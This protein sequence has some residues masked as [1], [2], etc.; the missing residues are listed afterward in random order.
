MIE[1][2]VVA[3]IVDTTNPAVAARLLGDLARLVA[4]DPGLE[5]KALLLENPSTE[6]A[7]S[8]LQLDDI[9]RGLAIERIAR[10][11]VEG[12][13]ARGRYG[14]LEPAPGRWPIATARTVLQR[15]AAERA[16]RSADAV[17]ILDE[18]LR[19]SPLLDA[20]KNGEP[21]LSARVRRLRD[22]RIDVAVG[23]TLGSPP[24]PARG[25]ARVNLEDVRRHLDEVDRLPPDAAWPDHAAENARTRSL[26]PEYYYDLSR[27]H[28][29][30]GARPMWFERRS[31]DETV[32]SAFARLCE[33]VGGLV[34]GIPVTRALPESAPLEEA[35]SPLARGG[36]TLVLRPELLARIPN[37]APRIGGR[38]TRRSDMLW[39]R[40][41]GALLGARFSRGSIVTYHD[42]RGQGRSSFDADKLVDDL[43]GSALVA[44]L[45][46]LLESGQIQRR[47]RPSAAAI[48]RAGQLYV[49]R[50]EE[51]LHAIRRSE[52]RALD[53]LDA[54]LAR[55]APRP[56]QRGFLFHPAHALPVARLRAHAERLRSAYG[57]SVVTC[58]PRA[59]LADVTR[60]FSGLLDEVDA[61]EINAP[62]RYRP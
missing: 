53:L 38:V 6:R 48:E 25:A 40:L 20:V 55:T 42:R 59:E 4:V 12:D 19:L 60:F 56:T 24:V 43:H 27:A 10:V 22:E 13:L 49:A 21:P 1:R 47:Q 32:Q 51:R 31:L 5:L 28:A 54:I 50:A 57:S 30:A 37:L 3:I 9:A 16:L 26:L 7:C 52:A 11:S 34:D 35:R 23:P 62:L 61:Y 44:A 45:D 58:D 33:A 14:R 17:W 36:N 29:D 2:L 46:L 41:A 15:Q 8:P 39:A 18:D